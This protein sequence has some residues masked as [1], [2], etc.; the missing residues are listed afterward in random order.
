[1]FECHSG[2]L[3][4][5][6]PCYLTESINWIAAL[7]MS[8]SGAFGR[9]WMSISFNLLTGRNNVEEAWR[10]L[11]PDAICSRTEKRPVVELRHRLIGHN[12]RGAVPGYVTGGHVDALRR[13]VEGPFEF[14]VRRI[15]INDALNLGCLVF[16]DTVDAGLVW[17]TCGCIWYE[18]HKSQSKICYLNV[19]SGIGEV[20]LLVHRDQPI[21]P[22][23]VVRNAR[24]LTRMGTYRARLIGTEDLCLALQHWIQR[25]NNC[26]PLSEIRL[27]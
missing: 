4:K 11:L 24:T 8:S 12:W 27:E 1:M 15:G 20:V 25:T 3:N 18:W 6:V 9:G 14:Y 7:P 5:H 17:R 16:R 10:L 2:N 26:R 23:V 22:W 21:H 19:Q 13:I